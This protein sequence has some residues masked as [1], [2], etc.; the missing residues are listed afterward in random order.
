MQFREFDFKQMPFLMKIPKFVLDIS[1]IL[2]EK[3][4]VTTTQQAIS[5]ATLI[6][7]DEYIYIVFSLR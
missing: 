6:S 7:P 2:H 3:I 5:Q 1:K 4:I